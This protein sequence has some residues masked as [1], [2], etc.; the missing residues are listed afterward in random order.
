MRQCS[1][2]IAAASPRRISDSVLAASS[3]LD[4]LLTLGS[5]T[6]ISLTANCTLRKSRRPSS[7]SMRV[8]FSSRSTRAPPD[9]RSSPLPAVMMSSRPP[10]SRCT[11][12]LPNS[13]PSRLSSVTNRMPELPGRSTKRPGSSPDTKKLRLASSTMFLAFCAVHGTSQSEAK[14]IISTSGAA[15]NA[16]GRHR[17][18]LP[19]PTEASTAISLS[20]YRRA[21]AIIRPMNSASG[22]TKLRK[23]GIR[24]TSN[25]SIRVA[26][27]LP[28]E[29][30]AIRSVRKPPT[31]IRN[32]TNSTAATSWLNCLNR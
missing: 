31:L 11:N 5:G 6:R 21:I 4:G 13:R 12:R 14:A 10:F 23:R 8:P 30:S 27:T 9:R 29:I 16:T 32:S 1:S 18:R 17:L 20:A 19:T 2:A 24:S 7:P 22:I 3:L 25:C 15:T 28:R 26:G